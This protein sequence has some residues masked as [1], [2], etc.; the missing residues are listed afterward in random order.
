M[1][2]DV[3]DPVSPS[4]ALLFHGDSQSL[5]AIVDGSGSWGS[6]VEA[7]DRARHLI[8]SRWQSARAWSVS[9]LVSD[10]SEIALST[11]ASLR[12]TEFGWSFSVTCLLCTRDSVECVA[13]GIYQVDILGPSG[14]MSLFRP[15]MLVD[16][17]LADG[18]LQLDAVAGFPHQNVCLGPFVGDRDQVSL[19]VARRAVEPGEFVVVTHANRY[20]LSAIR[21]PVSAQSLA[22]SSRPGALPAPVV[23]VERGSESELL[24]NISG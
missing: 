8:D 5:V 15:T 21:F 10:V 9:S 3:F 18:T 17:L 4:R 13:A 24:R 19:S 14:S 2:I 12:D 1:R 16:Q 7:A 6:G 23:V 22:A 20:D 11:P